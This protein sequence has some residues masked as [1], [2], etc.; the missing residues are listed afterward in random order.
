MTQQTLTNS[1]HIQA[2][3]NFKSS[4]ANT[5]ISIGRTSAWSDDQNPPA[6]DPS[7]T[8]LD[9]PIGYKLVG[10]C[11][12][13]RRPLEGET[14][15]ETAITYRSESW[16]IVPDDQAFTQNAKFLYLSSD[17]VGDELPLSTFRQIGLFTHLSPNNGVTKPNLL[18][19]EVQSIG[20]LEAF[21]NDVPRTRTID[22]TTTLEFLLQF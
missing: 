6:C 20:V 15:P 11:S 1:S 16:I 22:Q 2:A 3:L 7:I 8:I 17:I 10:T 21:I 4:Y 9:E 18:P 12:L 14:I 13:V 19:S 5:Y